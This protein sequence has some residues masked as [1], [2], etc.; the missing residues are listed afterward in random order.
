[1][2]D[3]GIEF[4]CHYYIYFDDG[5]KKKF[6]FRTLTCFSTILLSRINGISSEEP[7]LLN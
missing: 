4:K 1:M 3:I 5:M 2:N 6:L 7:L